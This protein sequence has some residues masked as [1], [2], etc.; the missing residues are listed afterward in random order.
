[1][2]YSF[3]PFSKLFRISASRDRSRWADPGAAGAGSLVNTIFGEDMSGETPRKEELAR[4][5]QRVLNTLTE[6]AQHAA[7]RKV[8]ELGFDPNKGRIS[9][10]ETLI[11][12][13]QGRDILLDAIEK[14]KFAQLPLKLQYALYDQVQAI[15]RELTALVNG[16]DAVQN[17]DK[18]VEELNASVWQFQLHNLSE[19]VLGFHSKMNQ[20]KNQETAIR[21]AARAAEQFEQV[22]Q[23]ADQTLIA[24]SDRAKS[25]A[26]EHASASK[27]V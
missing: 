9:L 17:L 10:E 11:N 8:G 2:C 27:L 23:K 1:M 3:G 20:L 5:L 21:Q 6:E 7:V 18:A 19:Q 25:I 4:E 12:L 26:D 15:A 24:I 22:R 16:T 14:S 13:T